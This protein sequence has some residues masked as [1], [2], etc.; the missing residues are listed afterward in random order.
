MIIDVSEMNLLYQFDDLVTDQFAYQNPNNFNYLDRLDN[1]IDAM[2]QMTAGLMCFL[3][4]NGNARSPYY[5]DEVATLQS[6]FVKEYDA[7]TIQELLTK[8]W[9]MEDLA[10]ARLKAL[11][12]EKKITFSVD[13]YILNESGKIKDDC[14]AEILKMIKKEKIT[15][16]SVEK[17]TFTADPKVNPDSC[18]SV[19]KSLWAASD[20]GSEQ[21]KQ[22][23]ELKA[24]I[25]KFNRKYN[26]LIA[27]LQP[28][29]EE[30]KLMK[31]KAVENDYN[32]FF[33]RSE[34]INR[35]SNM[36]LFKDQKYSRKIV[37]KKSGVYIGD[38]KKIDA[39]Y[40]VASESSKTYIPS[41][42]ILFAYDST[43][44][45]DYFKALKVDKD[46]VFGPASFKDKED[47]KTGVKTTALEF[48][49]QNFLVTFLLES[50]NGFAEKPEDIDLSACK[51]VV[52][53]CTHFKAKDAGFGSRKTLG[54]EISE[55]VNKLRSSGFDPEKSTDFFNHF[56]GAVTKDRLASFKDSVILLIGDL[57]SEIDEVAQHLKSKILR[58]ESQFN[59]QSTKIEPPPNGVY[60]QY[61]S[62]HKDPVDEPVEDLK[63]PKAVDPKLKLPE[64][65]EFK[66]IQ[67]RATK[68][69]TE[70]F[71]AD[72]LLVPGSKDQIVPEVE[73]K[74]VAQAVPRERVW[75]ETNNFP[76]ERKIRLKEINYDGRVYNNLLEYLEQLY[77]NH[78]GNSINPKKY[79]CFTFLD[80]K[81]DFS[82]SVPKRT[83]EDTDKD[84]QILVKNRFLRVGMFLRCL[85][86]FRE[87]LLANP[88]DKEMRAVYKVFYSSQF[89]VEKIDFILANSETEDVLVTEIKSVSD[90]V[91]FFHFG[92]PNPKY[93]SDHFPTKVTIK[94]GGSPV[95]E[96]SLKLY[97]N[98]APDWVEKREKEILLVEIP[99]D[100]DNYTPKVSS[101][102]KKGELRVI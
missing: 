5:I 65:D 46:F 69:N 57:N 27:E 82:Y 62:L 25:K 33:I 17:L 49:G 31:E 97:P 59:T 51:K 24:L 71:K 18:E 90:Y 60:Y 86:C 75:I 61:A 58:L 67:N 88:D 35:I 44:Y 22:K 93:G 41:Q 23:A 47:K 64:D 29:F 102:T 100:F 76:T 73:E 78:Q 15:A 42:S 34:I 10:R 11:M 83:I 50:E 92:I 85:E 68:K 48:E 38:G 101:T 19:F 96:Q 13:A 6:I 87:Y 14:R 63:I 45:F 99:E 20:D 37:A 98:L 95:S 39:E 66:K 56:K 89:E 12:A 40:K 16:S 77:L 7:F 32:E 2:N 80:R 53:I 26:D 70:V 54:G 81:K 84:K 28:K 74:E 55:F 1:N 8:T 94:V 52:V 21:A 91:K 72:V 3:E 9:K 43:K 36:N 30:V 79:D 4:W